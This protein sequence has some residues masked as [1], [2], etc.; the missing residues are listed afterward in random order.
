MAQ[1]RDQ[2]TALQQSSPDSSKGGADS[3]KYDGTPD[4][5]LTAFSPEEGSARSSKAIRPLTLSL[6][7]PR[8]TKFSS[9]QSKAFRSNDSLQQQEKDPFVTAPVSK[10]EQKLSATASAFRPFT[11]ILAARG[12]GSSVDEDLGTCREDAIQPQPMSVFRETSTDLQLSRCLVISSPSRVVTVSDVKQLLS[13]SPCSWHQPHWL[14]PGLTMMSQRFSALGLPCQ[15][16]AQIICKGICGYIRFTNLRE[17]CMVRC[18]VQLGGADWVAE[19]IS[20]PDFVQV[21]S[22]APLSHANRRLQGDF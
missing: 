4:T 10:P 16:E 15:G 19:F 8:P 12:T 6:P 11:Q 13:V 3:L 2:A 21:R 17:A 14:T 1:T 20:P 9:T 18:N 5:R 22:N 7:D